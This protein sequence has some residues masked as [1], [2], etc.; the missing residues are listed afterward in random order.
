MKKKKIF[1]CKISL[2]LKFITEK[3]LLKVT[4]FKIKLKKNNYVLILIYIIRKDLAKL[5][6]QATI[7]N[8]IF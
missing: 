7:H 5:S 3:K 6:N 8:F 4:Q 2:I 1:F